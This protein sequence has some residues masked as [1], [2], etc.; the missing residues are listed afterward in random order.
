[1]LFSLLYNT[2]ARISE[3]L[4]LKP[5]DVQHRVVR[6]HGKGRKERDVPLWPQTHRKLQQWC[7]DNKLEPAQ[8]IF[9]NPDGQ[10]LTR[11]SA[12][13]R[14]ALALTKAKETCSALQGRK[15][16]LHTF[17]HTT[18]MHL[19]Q[20]GVPMEIIALWLGH[21][22]VVTTHGYIEADLTMKQAAL[23]HLQPLQWRRA[24][25]RSASHIMAFL[26]AL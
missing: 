5:A 18:A 23:D 13:R 22:Q 11:R 2:G 25:K 7:R 17:R 9:G 8:P 3:A 12:A 10:A 26:E 20:A 15:I 4:Q 16:S 19:L 21:E 6:L 1:M 14:F 24:P